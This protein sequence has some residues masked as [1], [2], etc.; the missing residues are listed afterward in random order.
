MPGKLSF[1]LAV[2]VALE[3]T[4]LVSALPQSP[5]RR[6]N[7]GTRAVSLVRRP[8]T[9]KTAEEWGTWAYAHR[10]RMQAKYGGPVEGKGE[11][12]R[13]SSG[14]NMMVNQGGDSSYYGTMSLGTPG[15]SFNVILDTG[16]SDLWVAD[17]NCQAGCTSISTFQ[18]SSSSTFQN[19]STPFQITYGSG[20][21]QGTLARDVVQMAG[22]AVPNQVFATCDLVS[23]GLLQNPVSGL[24]GLAF[25]TIASSGAVPFWQT[26]ASG[27]A[28]D[29]PVMG[30]Y[31]TRFNNVTNAQKLEPG[32]SFDM[33]FTNTSLYQGDIDYVAL[34]TK[35]TYW[36]LPLNSLSVND[37]SIS[38]PSGSSSY[39]AIDTGTTLVGGPKSVIAHLFGQIPGSQPGTGNFEGYYTY[40]CNTPVIVRLGFGNS[41]QT[42]PISSDDFK[43]SELDQGQCLGAFFELSGGGS[44]PPWIIGDTFLKNVYSVFRYDP[45]SVGFANLS[46]TAISMNGVTGPVPSST[47]GS[48]VATV[49]ATGAPTTLSGDATSSTF[50]MMGAMTVVT[51]SLM[52]TMVGM[53]M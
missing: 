31:L 50:G 45:P 38:I 15:T 34:P 3:A 18:S 29:S 4:T 49:S 37:S 42:W 10:R 41:S 20:Q 32:G 19:L 8:Q 46:S 30:F 23:S 14:T 43:L 16:S 25:S 26:L 22:F 1:T 44:A 39:A 40:P 33:G 9:L 51:T 24:M 6:L 17:S 27:G 52:A 5:K 21:A 13:R 53:L 28:W 47:Q 48:T 7:P 11:L 35:A 36:I 2:L 12:G